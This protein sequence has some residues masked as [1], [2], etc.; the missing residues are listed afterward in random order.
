MTKKEFQRQFGDKAAELL[1]NPTFHIML[2]VAREE[3][4]Y[5]SGNTV[6]EATGI[7]RN[8]GRVTGWN[9]CLRFLKTIAQSDPEPVTPKPIPLYADPAK[10]KS[11]QNK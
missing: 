10:S 11:D 4:P 3:C 9:E 1:S 7:I 6:N 2:D 5:T 8:E